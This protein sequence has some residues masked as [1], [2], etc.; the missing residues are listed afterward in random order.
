M[1]HAATVFNYLGEN[2]F[3]YVS[4]THINPYIG[5]VRGTFFALEWFDFGA[6][7]PPLHRK[8]FN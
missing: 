4:E 5:E 7:G 3:N 2:E 8:V 1:F 6:Y